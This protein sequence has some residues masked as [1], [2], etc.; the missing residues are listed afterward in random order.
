MARFSPFIIAAAI[1][2]SSVAQ[3][4][5]S[6]FKNVDQIAR[7][8]GLAQYASSTSQKTVKIAVLDNGFKGAH[9]EIGKTLP[10]STQIRP[11]PVAVD[12][13]TEEAHGLAMAQIVSSLLA[14]TPGIAY[15]LHLF[16][17]YG[18]TNL[19]RAIDLVIAEKFD[20]V[21][22]AQVWEYGGNGDGRG[23]INALVN[24]ATSAGVTWIS[25]AGNF[26]D[27][28]YRAAVEKGAD[29]WAKLP[30]PNSS[31]RVRCQ[32]NPKGV[33][34]LR[35]VLSWND[36]KDD[37]KEGTEKDLDLVLSDD[38]LKI[39]RTGGLQQVK[40]S[41]TPMQPRTTLYPREIVEAELKPGVYL[42]RAKIRSQNFNSQRDQ[43]KILASG[44]YVEL[45]DRNSSAETLLAPAD[46]AS[47]ITVGASD[48]VK[49]SRSASLRKPEFSTFSAV[50]TQSGDVFK[51]SSNVAAMTTA[52]AA[53]L[54]GTNPSLD[55]AS[56][57]ATLRTRTSGGRAGPPAPP[58][59]PVPPAPALSLHELEFGSVGPGCFARIP[60]TFT[61]PALIPILNAGGIPVQTTVGLKIFTAVDPYTLIPGLARQSAN[62]MLVF[63]GVGF[64]SAPRSRQRTL[65]PRDFE[66][67]QKPIDAFYCGMNGR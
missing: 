36:F 18:Y 7:A 5:T 12:P 45:L 35:A 49:S 4:Q 43:L 3:S 58:V 42:L 14:K 27:S 61:P 47:V 16:S 21:L 1:L 59:E 64:Y 55:R 15:E 67:V 34:S 23:F 50:E 20:L 10:A 6:P 40:V 17:A 65:G 56:L 63:G 26:G 54:K 24:R 31:V 13:A 25:A 19:E 29:D 57:T 51:G 28:I 39:L 9:A 38:T 33:C 8:I 60:L 53:I 22:Y 11:G 52:L 62:D 41:T 44:D 66:V 32:Q 48:S 37:V 46:N 30:S 2:V